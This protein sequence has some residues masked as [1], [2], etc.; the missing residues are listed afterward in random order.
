MKMD[1]IMLKM[2]KKGSSDGAFQQ[3]RIEQSTT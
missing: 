1:T 2:L 3:S